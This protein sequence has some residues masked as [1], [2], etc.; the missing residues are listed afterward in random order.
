MIC[1]VSCIFNSRE[2]IFPFE[3]RIV[4][5]NLVESRSGAQ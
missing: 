1:L 5:E 3:V 4:F 2:N